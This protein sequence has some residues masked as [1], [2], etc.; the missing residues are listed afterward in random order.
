MYYLYK[1]SFKSRR[2][3]IDYSNEFLKQCN[4]TVLRPTFF[5]FFSKYEQQN[6][7]TLLSRIYFWVITQGKYEIYNLMYNNTI[8][9]TSYVVPKCSKFSFLEK[10][11]FEIGPCFTNREYRRKGSYCYMLDYILTLKKYEDKIFY[12]IVNSKNEPSIK[13]IEKAGFK[14][15]G[16]V[17]KTRMLKRYVKESLYE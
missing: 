14:K 6:I 1:R 13:G 9:H 10:C 16:V 17:R 3:K 15:Y 4:V 7:Y 12:M 2:K 8:V 5:Q 11:D